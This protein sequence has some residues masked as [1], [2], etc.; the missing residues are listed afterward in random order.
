MGAHGKTFQ[1]PSIARFLYD[2]IF[3]PEGWGWDGNGMEQKGLR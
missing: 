1:T 2:E 3:L